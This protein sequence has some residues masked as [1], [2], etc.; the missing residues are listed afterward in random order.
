MAN[1]GTFDMLCWTPWKLLWK[2]IKNR[3]HWDVSW[4]LA[5]VWEIIE[6]RFSKPLLQYW[7]YSLV[8][9]SFHGPN[10]IVFASVSI[11]F[12]GSS[13]VSCLL[14]LVRHPN[15]WCNNSEDWCMI[16]LRL[17]SRGIHPFWICCE[18]VFSNS[19]WIAKPKYPCVALFCKN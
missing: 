1:S 13:A 3:M 9:L 5:K 14:S 4:L 19:H 18:L 17:L 15:K 2:K 8:G 7:P 6:N 10:Q 12:Y 16:G 11:P